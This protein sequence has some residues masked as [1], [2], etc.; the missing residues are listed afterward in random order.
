MVPCT[1][2][3]KYPV[4][5]SLLH[6]WEIPGD[7]ASPPNFLFQTDLARHRSTSIPVWSVFFFAFY[8]GAQPV[9][10]S[11]VRLGLTH[12]TA[13][14]ITGKICVLQFLCLLL[15]CPP[16]VSTHTFL[17]PLCVWE[18][19]LCDHL[20]KINKKRRRG[21]SSSAGGGHRGKR[22]QIM[23]SES[24]GSREHTECI[25]QHWREIDSGQYI[26]KI[27]LQVEWEGTQQGSI[28]GIK[29]E[30]HCNATV[31]ALTFFI[32]GCDVCDLS[33]TDH[34]Y[35]L[36]ARVWGTILL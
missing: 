30:E 7:S 22:N 12:P 17:S 33:T 10:T 24:R 18:Q 8:L 28:T 4:L 1:C 3:K 5:F 16:V 32:N 26:E 19:R 9:C 31:G 21:G 13:Q 35:L 27:K 20:Q 15:P 29:A 23:R 14:L 11:V 34:S 36:F 6:L 2:I 25:Q